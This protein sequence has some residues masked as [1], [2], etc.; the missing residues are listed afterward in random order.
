MNDEQHRVSQQRLQENSIPVDVVAQRV[1]LHLRTRM[2]CPL[3]QLP[4][5]LDLP[6][7]EA[8]AGVLR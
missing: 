2:L 1:E 7:E 6:L 4:W 5:E 8:E 3:L